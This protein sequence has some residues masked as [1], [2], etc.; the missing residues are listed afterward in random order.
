MFL[1]GV[2]VVLVGGAA[3]PPPGANELA[4]QRLAGLTP[5]HVSA[6]LRALREDFAL[7]PAE[8]ERLGAGVAAALRDGTAVRAVTFVLIL[9]I[10]G[11]GLEWLYWTFAAA[12]LR[13][14]IST[15]AAT[16]R[17]AALLALRRLALLGFGLVSFTASTV[18]AALILPW[19][20]NVDAIVIAATALVV[21]VRSAWI[22]ADIVVS[23][24]HPSLRLAPIEQYTSGFV[25]GGVAWLTLLTA[26][27]IL[28][29]QLLTT[30][31]AA[32]HL[33]ETVRVGIGMGAHAHTRPGS[34]SASGYVEKELPSSPDRRTAEQGNGTGVAI[35]PFRSVMK[36]YYLR[37][38][39]I[40]DRW[41]DDQDSCDR[42]GPKG[43]GDCSQS[44]GLTGCWVL[45][46]ARGGDL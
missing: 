27:A 38:L 31:G 37:G 32:P 4:V 46:V 30:V 35:R 28:L 43:R 26:A 34:S 11:A 13:A 18:G 14:I 36:L 7:A 15:A 44:A 23:P 41:K 19:S 1:A 29:P 42:W 22:I 12:S 33:A 45:R 5:D 2:I 21:T 3:P 9:V 17:E 25:V 10:V 6:N 39:R 16:P 24:H 40:P 20:V 8:A